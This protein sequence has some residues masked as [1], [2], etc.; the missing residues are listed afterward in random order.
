MKVSRKGLTVF[1]T[2]IAVLLLLGL[3]AGLYCGCDGNEGDGGSQSE[4]VNGQPTLIFFTSEQCPPCREMDPVYDE[5]SDE[6]GDKVKFLKVDV[7]EDS[8]KAYQYGIQ[9]TPTVIIADSDGNITAN[10]I[11]VR[12]RDEVVTEIER[13]IR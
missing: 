7:Y 11:G 9:Y 13:V 5:L 10:L 6:Y 4:A 1:T 2:I 3:T 8:Q 12:S